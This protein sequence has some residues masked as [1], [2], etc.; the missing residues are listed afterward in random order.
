ML[1]VSE[2]SLPVMNDAPTLAERYYGTKQAI[3]A[4]RRLTAGPWSVLLMQGMLRDICYDGIEVIRSI[5][6]LVRDRDWGTCVPELRGL[7][8]DEQGSGF[9]IAYEAR[10]DNADGQLLAY[11]ILI[12]CEAQGGLSFHA[13]CTAQTEFVTARCG[14]CILHPIDGVAGA[15]ARVEHGDGSIERSHF[16]EAI[17]PWQPFMDIRSIEHELK[18]GLTVRCELSGD[19][20][21]MEDQRNWSDASFKTYS[22][23]LA[24][25]W[26][27]TLAA[28]EVNEQSVRLMVKAGDEPVGGEQATGKPAG[29]KR[30]DDRDAGDKPVG[31]K[32]GRD[33]P[34]GDGHVAKS[35]SAE[36]IAVVSLSQSLHAPRTVM[37]ALG[38]AVAPLEIESVLANLERLAEL[39]PQHL[40]LHFDPLAGHGLSELRQYVYLVRRSGLPATLECALPG[41][42]AP[43]REL[44]TLAAWVE[45]AGLPLTGVVVSPSVHRESNPPGSISPPCPPLDEVYREAR[46]A[47]PGLRLGGGML[48]YFTELNRKRPPLEL[49]DVVTHATCPIVHAADDRSVMETLEAVPHITRSCRALIGSRPYVIG[50]VSIGMRQNPYGSRVMPN[51]ARE[52]IAMAEDDPRQHGLFGAAWLAGYAAALADA[53]LECLT[54]GAL[55]GPRGLIADDGQRYPV[56]AVAAVLARLAGATRIACRSTR[57]RDVA[58]FA[59]RAASGVT[60]LVIANLTPDEQGCR[61]D[62]AGTLCDEMKQARIATLDE[63]SFMRLRQGL[64]EWR[65]YD[66]ARGQLTLKSFAC[67]LLEWGKRRVE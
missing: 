31:D 16:P 3:P 56:F 58:A 34:A 19:V 23:P 50:P 12:E 28:G 26:P 4:V 1:A 41:V 52:R 45:Q 6:Y 29:D 66:A 37:A 59:A 11:R 32:Q 44:A 25:P 27:Y 21:E 51:P 43:G 18:Q 42:D 35:A 13:V 54:L 49:V 65:R 55:T 8:V 47:F 22:R 9:R 46:R 64:P 17:D 62:P 24:L 7:A 53:D 15:P 30:A 67:V 40:L 60:T 57:G 39:A 36:D 20:F 10:C 5:A 2:G 63:Q 33:R 38:L 14:F 48:S 61:L